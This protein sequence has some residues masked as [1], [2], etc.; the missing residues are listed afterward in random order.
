[1]NYFSKAAI[2]ILFMFALGCSS[3]SSKDYGYSSVEAKSTLASPIKARL[4]QKSASLGINVD[5]VKS[6]TTR[7]YEIIDSVNGY[8]DSTNNYSEESTKL[9]VKVPSDKLDQTLENLSK[10]GEVTHE[11]KSSRDV[12]DEV[13]D[14]EARLKNLIELRDRF[15]Q[16]LIK[17]EKVEEILS[18]ER[19]LSR[20]QTEIDSIESRKKMLIGNVALSKID[21]S[22]NQKTVLGPL[23]YLAKGLYWTISK[24]FVI[25]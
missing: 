4:I 17:A 13:V 3:N 21:I 16:L 11:R 22:L 10:I 15:R 9:V 19:E 7:V 20:V 6:S 18:I 14:I 1:M 2:F 24:L 12:T 25:Q 5:S 8:V 23:G